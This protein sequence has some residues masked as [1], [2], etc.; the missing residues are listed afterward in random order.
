MR[1]KTLILFLSLIFSIPVSGQELDDF[2]RNISLHN[3]QII[4]Y[5]KL[6]EARRAESRTGLTPPDPF[7]TGSYM[8]G[9]NTTAGEKKT[10]EI[11]QSFAFPV[12]YLLM[13]Q[14]S[15]S[16][17]LIAEQE[18]NHGRL[19]VML[20]AELLLFDLIHNK[21]LLSLITE[22]KKDHDALL[23][24]WKKMLDNGAAT[25]MDYNRILIELSGINLQITRIEAQIAMLQEQ[26]SYISGSE[27]FSFPSEYPE[28][29]D[30]G[31]EQI[32]QEKASDH[33]A[34]LIPE[35]EYRIS[36]QNVKLSRSENLPEL[37]IGYGA[38]LVPGENYSGPVGGLSIPLWSNA[39]KVKAASARAQHA[40][41]VRDAQMQML[42]TETRNEY[43]NMRALQ[44]NRSEIKGILG[45]GES[46]KLLDKAL[47]SGEIT[48]TS[49]FSYLKSLFDSE[50]M[51]LQ[52]ENEYYKS[53]ARLTDHHLLDY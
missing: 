6:L 24:A 7:I 33:P 1:I 4:A 50:D 31:I 15:K 34:Y 28:F 27:I 41:A 42:V 19:Q 10:W 23:G 32:I 47:D 17:L 48:L 16:S 35:M 40:A 5:H 12:K 38:E 49:Y 26:L 51:Y 25:I 30:N 53:F 37:Q 8:P 11:T 20:D 18:F 36:L 22:R 44:K 14:I 3:P 45:T 29:T 52:A 13:K 46:K 9:Q 2:F 43:L 21:K 39:S